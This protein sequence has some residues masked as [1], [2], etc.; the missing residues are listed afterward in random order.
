MG[1][2]IHLPHIIVFS[3]LKQIIHTYIR[4]YDGTYVRP[5]N[6]S[7]NSLLECTHIES[8]YSLSYFE[9]NG[10]DYIPMESQWWE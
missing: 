10:A 9:S 3:H 4:T 7:Y 2:L 6:Y 1:A 5:M 8:I